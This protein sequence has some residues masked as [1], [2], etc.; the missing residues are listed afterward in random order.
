MT[1]AGQGLFAMLT[2]ALVLKGFL[3]G[4]SVA[5]PPGPINAE[6]LRRGL[7]RGF[8][9]AYSV[10]LG[11]CAGDFLWALAVALG[12]GALLAS[13]PGFRPVFGAVSVALLLFL[14]WTFAKGARWDWQRRKTLVG[15]GQTNA[16]KFDSSRGGFLLGLGMALSSPWN[17]A[18]WLAVVG[19]QAGGERLGPGASMLVATGVLAGAMTWGMLFC[20]TLRLGARRFASPGWLALTQGTTAA[21]MLAFAARAAWKLTVG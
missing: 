7:T 14:A 18:F 15:T 5:W 16:G 17:V 12:A 13:V 2:L 8:W 19:A 3:L 6:M 9:P 4:W 11:A 1:L 21:L 20:G 10:G